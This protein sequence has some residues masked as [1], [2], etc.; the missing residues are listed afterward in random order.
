MS[1][2]NKDE[3]YPEDYEFQSPIES[4]EDADIFGIDFYKLRIK[5]F[6]DPEFKIFLYAKKDLFKTKIQEQDP[7]RGVLWMQGYMII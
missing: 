7:L 3:D 6:N 1:L 4:I 5:I 2:I